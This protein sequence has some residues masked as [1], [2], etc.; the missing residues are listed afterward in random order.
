MVTDIYY[1]L[2][3]HDLAK[4]MNNGKNIILQELY[5]KEL[6]DKDTYDEY[7]MY[8]GFMLGQPTFFTKVWERFIGKKEGGARYMLVKVVNMPDK[9]TLEKYP[10]MLLPEDE[11][12]ETK[13]EDDESEGEDV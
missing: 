9:E 1:T 13:E 2:S 4:E 7:V 5:E 8:Y 11:I 3:R 6:I 12:E 10:K